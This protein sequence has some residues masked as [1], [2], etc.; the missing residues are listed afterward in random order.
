M[1]AYAKCW[2]DDWTVTDTKDFVDPRILQLF[3]A[4]DRHVL[5]YAT[6]PRLE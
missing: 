1:G 3:R 2:L 6:S 4:E 5:L